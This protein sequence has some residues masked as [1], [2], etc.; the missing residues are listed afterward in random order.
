[1]NAVIFADL[2]DWWGIRSDYAYTISEFKYSYRRL[3]DVELNISQVN[4]I[5]QILLPFVVSPKEL[6]IHREE[7][8]KRFN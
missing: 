8:N 3:S 4:A 2:E 1:M 5:Y 7:T 6:E